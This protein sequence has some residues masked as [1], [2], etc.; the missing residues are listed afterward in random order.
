MSPRVRMGWRVSNGAHHS[1][2]QSTYER[3]GQRSHHR[4]TTLR[5][6]LSVGRVSQ[7]CVNQSLEVSSLWST[8]HKTRKGIRL[9]RLS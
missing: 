1:I 6:A 9:G 3:Y 8:H 2:V 4:E 7:T 5:S